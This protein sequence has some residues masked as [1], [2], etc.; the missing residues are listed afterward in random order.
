VDVFAKGMFGS[1]AE[2]ALGEAAITVNKNAIPFDANPPM[3]P[4]GIRIGTPA[5]TTRGMK[6]EQMRQVGR[7]ISEALHHRTEA[8]ILGQIQKQVLDLAEAFPL[9]PQRRAKAQVEVRA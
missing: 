4:S 5:L 8:P 1:E 2:K 3:K 7:W 6:E 9:Y